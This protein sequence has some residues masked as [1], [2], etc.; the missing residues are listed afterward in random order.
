[1]DEAYINSSNPALDLFLFQLAT[2]YSIS[3]AYSPGEVIFAEGDTGRTMLLILHGIVKIV[4]GSSE[5]GRPV[6][7]AKRGAGE[8]FG[9]MALVEQSPRFAS[10]VAVTDCE[11]LEFSKENFERIIKEQPALAT[12]VLR[13]LSKKLRESDSDRIAELEES[14]RLLDA[15]NKELKRLNAFLDTVIDQ[16][17]TAIFITT[18]SGG[19]FRKNEAAVRMFDLEGA[20]EDINVESLFQ[21]LKI[22]ELELDKRTNWH[23]EVTAK[24]GDRTFPSYIAVTSLTGHDNSTLYLVICQDISELQAFNNAM[25]DLEKYSS[26][27]S[28]AAEFAH[29]LKNYFGAIT[30]GVDLLVENLPDEQRNS[31]SKSVGAVQSS[32]KQ[33]MSYVDKAMVNTGGQADAKTKDVTE[34]INA[35]IRF[36]KTQVRFQGIDLNLNVHP[37]TPKEIRLK[38]VQIQSV[39]LNLLVNAAEAL[40]EKKGDEMRAICVDVIPDFESASLHIKITDNGPGINP[41]FLPKLFKERQTT[42]KDGHGIGLV[43][44][45]KIINSHGGAVSVNSEPGKG[46]MFDVV[47]PIEEGGL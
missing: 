4:K 46:A 16:S 12:R 2:K 39:I 11:V 15:S 32:V 7:I 23:G 8:F 1:M 47:L 35:V 44:V 18:Y 29:D 43:S 42:K 6:E 38:E 45:G 14:N 25:R 27:Q 40:S 36:C 41:E 13:S 33:I 20:S 37:D 19:I 22:G 28:T 26:A 21:N 9:E 31:L 17:P 5:D 3:K 34:V 30:C 10:V 24:R